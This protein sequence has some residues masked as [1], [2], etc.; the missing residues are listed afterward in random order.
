MK[1]T[2]VFLGIITGM[3]SL[4]SGA[5]YVGISQSQVSTSV[6]VGFLTNSI[7]Q[8]IAVSLPLLG[9][10]DSGDDGY[11][12]PVA[13]MNLLYKR[14]VGST[15][16]LGVGPTLRMG[17]EYEKALCLQAGFLV[18]VSLEA[19]GVRDIL[20]CEL[21]YLPKAWAWSEGPASSALLE[22]G[23]GQFVRFGYRHAF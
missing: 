7:D 18:Q 3:L 1:K 10:L 6:E 20:F 12:Y 9:S 8:N 5:P 4:L 13:S 14:K 21:A 19:P 22:K 17:W 15:V 23:I 2:V 16:A 11:R